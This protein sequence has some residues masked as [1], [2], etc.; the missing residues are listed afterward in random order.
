MAAGEAENVCLTHSR[1]LEFEPMP[2]QTNL[3]SCDIL[4][5][6][7]VGVVLNGVAAITGKLRLTYGCAEAECGEGLRQDC[8]ANEDC[9]RN[10]RDF[11]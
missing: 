2:R 9:E 8:G 1:C 7:C 4:V 5:F 3:R 10:T 11:R 6:Y